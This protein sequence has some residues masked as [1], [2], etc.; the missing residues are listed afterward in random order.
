MDDERKQVTGAM[1]D[2]L[3]LM[4]VARDQAEMEALRDAMR[5]LTEYASLMTRK[6]GG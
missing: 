1:N 2:V 3:K 4:R 6:A 5:A